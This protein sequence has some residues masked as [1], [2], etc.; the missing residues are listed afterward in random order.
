MPGALQLLTVEAE[1]K[2]AL[3]DAL[4]RIALRL[5]GSTVPQQNRAAAI[6]ARGNG[7]LEIAVAKRM[8]L[9]LNREALLTLDQARALGHRPALQG[10]VELKTE[11]VVEARGIVLLH[12]EGGAAA[13]G[14]LACRLRGFREVALGAISCELCHGARA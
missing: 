6:L 10:A 2:A 14:G 13:P 11:I 5:P 8:V 3:L 1:G 12:D 7:A 4:V 9:D